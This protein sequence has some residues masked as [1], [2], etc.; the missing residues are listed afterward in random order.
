MIKAALLDILEIGIGQPAMLA[1][2]IALTGQG[3]LQLGLAGPA[4]LC[5]RGDA[6]RHFPLAGLDVDGLHGPLGP[7]CRSRPPVRMLHVSIDGFL[8]ALRK[9][10]LSQRLIAISRNGVCIQ[11]MQ[12][13]Q[14]GQCSAGAVF[15]ACGVTQ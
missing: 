5:P 2:V 1:K 15:M 9:Q 13:Q 4:H 12:A 10:G 8:D 11:G 3:V 7:V 14:A 6:Q